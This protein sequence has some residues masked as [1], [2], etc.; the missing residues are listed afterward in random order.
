MTPEDYECRKCGRLLYVPEDMDPLEQ[1]VR[2]CGPCAIDE[3]ERLRDE[4]ARAE[5]KTK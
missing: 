2:F 5:E 1:D 4:L 3:I